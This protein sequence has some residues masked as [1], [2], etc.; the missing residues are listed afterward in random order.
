MIRFNLNE[1]KFK[2]KY[3]VLSRIPAAAIK[4]KWI[5][6]NIKKSPLFIILLLLA[7]ITKKAPKFYSK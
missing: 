5:L 1:I 3:L 7:N 4:S 2:I 6:K